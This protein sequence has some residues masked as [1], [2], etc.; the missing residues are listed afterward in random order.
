MVPPAASSGRSA[1]DGVELELHGELKDP[2]HARV[3]QRDLAC[4]KGLG[5]N[6]NFIFFEL[7]NLHRTLNVPTYSV[8][9]SKK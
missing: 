2:P 8:E 7:S 1:A 9:I 5:L 3:A 4:K 6:L